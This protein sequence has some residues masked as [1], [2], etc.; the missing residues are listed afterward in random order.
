MNSRGP[1]AVKTQQRVLP[2]FPK[3]TS[4]ALASPDSNQSDHWTEFVHS[5]DEKENLHENEDVDRI[6]HAG[7]TDCY[8]SA[9]VGARDYGTVKQESKGGPDTYGLPTEG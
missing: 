8:P 1:S 4:A 2:Q 6:F 7:R 3:R 9:H 5:Q